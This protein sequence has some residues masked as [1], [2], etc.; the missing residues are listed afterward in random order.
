MAFTMVNYHNGG[1]LEYLSAYMEKS[2]DPAKPSL[3]ATFT[4]RAQTH[5]CRHFGSFIQT[6]PANYS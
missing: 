6:T 2:R 5:E 1:T 4:R 3:L